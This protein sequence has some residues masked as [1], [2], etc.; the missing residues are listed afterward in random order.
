MEIELKLKAVGDDETNMIIQMLSCLGGK[1]AP[2]VV[3]S[4]EPVEAP[5]PKAPIKVETEE[6]VK[7]V[8]QEVKSE[9]EISLED[10]QKT[11]GELAKAGMKPK[12]KKLLS[13]HEVKKVSELPT[14]KYS[15]VMEELEALKGA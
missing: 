14:E 4:E 11:F 1:C 6:P 3:K 10:L 2:L 15:I 9:I 13:K 7:E 12:L 8:K 5:K